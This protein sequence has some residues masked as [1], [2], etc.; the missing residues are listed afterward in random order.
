M[1]K[2]EA[3][4]ADSSRNLISVLLREIVCGCGKVVLLEDNKKRIASILSLFSSSLFSSV[5]SP[6]SLTQS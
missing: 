2:D 1:I 3:E 4:I 6:I 5:H